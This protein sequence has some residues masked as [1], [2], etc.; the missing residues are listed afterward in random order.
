LIRI[1]L[2]PRVPRRRLPGRQYFEIGI[3][4]VTLVVVI[5]LG[6][7]VAAASSRLTRQIAEVNKQVA[8]IRPTVDRVLELDRQ[9]AEMKSKESVITDLL[10]QQLPASS[11]LNEMRLLIPKD[12]WLT[13]LNVP[14]ASSLSI[15][16]FG[17]TYPSVAQLME[18][19]STGRLFRS[20]DLTV[21][22]SERVGGREVVKFSVT[23]RVQKPQ[24]VGGS[25]P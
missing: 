23:A 14:E 5:I 22:Q 16:G 6:L 10:A 8:E 18:N 11:V 7:I 15:E 12:V 20:V 17:M 4:A 24:A 2:L 13:S 9:I 21:V 1:N 25:R 19:L 3:P